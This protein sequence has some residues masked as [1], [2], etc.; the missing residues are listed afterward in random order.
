ML[1]PRVGRSPTFH[2]CNAVDTSHQTGNRGEE[3]RAKKPSRK[4]RVSLSS[5]LPAGTNERTNESTWSLLSAPY[6][7][8]SHGMRVARYAARKQK[9]AERT[10]CIYSSGSP[11]CSPG[12]T[13]SAQTRSFSVPFGIDSTHFFLL[14]PT[15]DPFS[16]SLSPTVPRSLALSLA[17]LPPRSF[18]PVSSS[19]LSFCS[20]PV[21]AISFF[22]FFPFVRSKHSFY[23]CF[24]L[25]WFFLFPPSLLWRFFSFLEQRC[26][27]LRRES[28]ARVSKIDNRERVISTDPDVSSH[29]FYFFKLPSSTVISGLYFILLGELIP[30]RKEIYSISNQNNNQYM[31]EINSCF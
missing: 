2:R 3:T 7:H 5:P 30:M 8:V 15:T 31:P 14:P 9:P 28:E 4:V 27:P 25:L 22:F 24:S 6:V 19:L 21:A 29:Y 1:A 17:P 18:R 11:H 26:F 12:P 13:D 23:L 20:Q 16:F 10:R